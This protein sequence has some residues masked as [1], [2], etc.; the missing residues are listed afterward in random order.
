MEKIY[1]K[2]SIDFY[3]FAVEAIMGPSMTQPGSVSVSGSATVTIPDIVAPD[4][5]DD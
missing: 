5:W 3:E 1:N 2:P 4:P